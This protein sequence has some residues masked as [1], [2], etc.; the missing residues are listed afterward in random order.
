MVQCGEKSNTLARR[1]RMPKPRSGT[2]YRLSQDA[3]DLLTRLAT[4]LGLTKTAVLEM[5]IRKL[6]YTELGGD[7][8]RLD[9]QARPDPRSNAKVFAEQHAS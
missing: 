9:F 4:R 6:A 7:E 3:Q 2:S 1:G 5:S 8:R